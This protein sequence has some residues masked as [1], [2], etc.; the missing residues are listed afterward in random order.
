MKEVIIT[1]ER[2]EELLHKEA[3]YELKRLEVKQSSYSSDIDKLLFE[4]TLTAV[5]P[6]DDN[7]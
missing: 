6:E 1:M 7:F 2:L 4:H 5:G 3:A